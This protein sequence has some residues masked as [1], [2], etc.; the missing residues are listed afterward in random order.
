[1]IAPGTGDNSGQAIDRDF[2][3]VEMWAERFKLTLET[4]SNDLEV[5]LEARIAEIEQRIS[6]LGG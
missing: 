6:D 2:S 1:M 5:A 4:W 3:E